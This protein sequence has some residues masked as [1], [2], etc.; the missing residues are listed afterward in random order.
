MCP[1]G[2]ER[3]YMKYLP[4]LLLFLGGAAIVAGVALMSIPASLITAGVLI[5]AA[6]IMI[7][8][9]AGHE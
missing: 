3:G 4:T 5:S 9:G 1:I 2:H 7:I 6:A 8:K